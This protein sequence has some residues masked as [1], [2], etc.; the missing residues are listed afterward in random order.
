MIFILRVDS[1]TFCRFCGFRIKRNFCFAMRIY[2]NTP[3][4]P[5]CFSC[6]ENLQ[7]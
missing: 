1:I 5:V 2:K 4:I 3:F 6:S 7:G